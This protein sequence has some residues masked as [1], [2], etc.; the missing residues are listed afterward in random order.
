[1]VTH[2]VLYRQF[3]AKIK[4]GLR[5]LGDEQQTEIR[6][7][8]IN[9]QHQS[10][11]FTDRGGAPDLYYSV[12]GS[13]MAEALDLKPEI[14][15]L[16]SWIKSLKDEEQGN[17]IHR[18]SL[19]F[20]QQ[21]LIQQRMSP[22]NLTKKL[23]LRDFPVNFSYQLFLALLLVDTAYG[24]KRWVRVFGRIMLTFYRLPQ[25]VPCSMVAALL[26]ARSSLKMRTASLQKNLVQ[27]FRPEKAF[28]AFAPMEEP[29]LLSTGV[30]L[31][32]LEKAQTDLREIAPDCLSFIQQNYRDG[33]FLAGDGD[34]EC[35]LEYTF[36]GLLALGSLGSFL[37]RTTGDQLKK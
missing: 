30:A 1:M 32:A 25:Q 33:A 36:Y 12:F 29:D 15:R 24:Q 23:L 22:L 9:S 19:L 4:L 35:D 17:G 13:W 7:F 18:F 34:P 6:Q 20:L 5:L 2:Q 37:A 16:E 31:F 28:V 26:V 27:Y 11:G 3:I 14:T 21:S 8:V 10:G